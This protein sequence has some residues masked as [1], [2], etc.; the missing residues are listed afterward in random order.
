MRYVVTANQEIE[1]VKSY[2]GALDVLSIEIKARHESTDRHVSRKES[3]VL[4]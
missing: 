2:C 3:S 1:R 4:T